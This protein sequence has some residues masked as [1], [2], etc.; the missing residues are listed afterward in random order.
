MTTDQQWLYHNL[1]LIKM[2]GLFH[3]V[4]K[5]K[6]SKERHDLLFMWIKQEQITLKEYKVLVDYVED[7]NFEELGEY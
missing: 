4:E 2:E 5:L 1:Q 7:W 3:K 6:Q